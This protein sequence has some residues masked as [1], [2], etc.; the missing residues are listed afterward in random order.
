MFPSLVVAAAVSLSPQ[1]ELPQFN[2]FASSNVSRPMKLEALSPDLRDLVTRGTVSSVERR[3]GVPTFFWASR[4]KGGALRDIGLTPEQA[5]RRYLFA[6]AALYRLQPA[7]LADARLARLHDIGQGAIV[8]TFQKDA[9][10]IKVFNDE[11][12]IVMNQK[13]ELIAITGYV[14]PV[15]RVLGT[16]DLTPETAVGVAYAELKGA[17]LEAGMLS[18]LRPDGAGFNRYALSGETTPVRARKVYFALP[19]GLTPGYQLELSVA[20][21]YYSY[22]VSAKDGALL[23]RNNL[24][25]NDFS[26]RVWADNTPLRMPLDGPQGDDPTPHPTGMP[27]DYNPPFVTNTL[28]T[29]AN[30]PI[31]TND[32]WLA[33]TA[34]TTDGNNT[35]A[36]ADL[37]APDGFS[38]GD[39]MPDVTMP[40]VFDRTYDVTVSPGVT[41]DQTKAA[42]TQ[43]FYDVN[44]FHDWYYDVGFDEKAGNGQ[45]SNYGRGG[46][47]GDPVLAEGQDYSGRNNSDMSTPSDGASPRMQMYIFD[48]GVPAW[49]NIVG[50]NQMVTA[51]VADF[52]AQLFDLTAELA[53]ANDNSS[54]PTLGCGTTW[55]N[56]VAGKIAVVDRGTCTFVQKAENAQANGAIGVLILNNQA[57]GAIPMPG[58]S[59]IATIPVLSMGRTDGTS[60]KAKMMMGATSVE[61]KRVPVTDRDGTIDNAIVAHEWGHYIQNRLVGDGNGLTNNQGTG[62]GEG[63]SD[64]HAMLLVVK[65]EDAQRPANQNYNG[66]YALAGYTMYGQDPNAYYWGIRR[67]PYSTDMTKNPFTFKHIQEGT[68]LP[69]T[70]PLSFGQNG[71]GNSEVHNTGEVWSEMLWECYASLLRDT[72]RLTFEQA[73]DR[74][75]A[76]L[77]AAYK[78]TPILPTFVEARDAILASAI[79]ADPTDFALFW[80][81]FAKRGI[82]M[83]AVAPDRD[84]QDNIPVVESFLVGNDLQII[85]VTLDDSVTSCDNDGNLDLGETGK[86][87]VT[88]KN[89]G[90]G[91]L[92]QTTGTVTSSMTGLRV[93]GGNSITFPPIPPFGIA[94]ATVQVTLDSAPGNT[95]APFSIQ[96]SDPSL[97]KPGPVT[98]TPQFRVN[99]DAKPNGSFT[100]D[101]EAPVTAWTFSDDPNGV[102]G[103]DFRIYADSATSHWFF[104]PDPDAPA[105]TYL[106]SPLMVAG[107]GPVSFTFVH[108]YQ[109]ET[110]AQNNYD[111]AV[112]EI[113]SGTSGWQDLGSKLSQPYDAKISVG[114]NNPIEGRMAFTGQSMNYPA[115][116]P[117]TVD[118]GTQYAGKSFKIRFRVGS[119]DAVGLKGWE[120]DNFAFVGIAS[121]PFPSVVTDP[122]S[123]TN[124]PPVVQQPPVRTVDEGS[125]VVLSAIA[126]DPD[127]DMVT[128]AFTQIAGPLVPMTGGDAFDAPMVDKDTELDFQVIASDGRATSAPVTQVVIVRNVNKPPVAA[129]TP[130]TQTVDEGTMVT[131]TGSA[132]DPEGDAIAAYK[133]TQ[134]S[135]PAVS[136]TGASTATLT[137]TAPQV[138]ADTVMTFQLVAN[139]G[140]SDGPGAL[141]TVTV[142]NVGG[143]MNMMP[144]PMPTPTPKGC[145]CGASDTTATAWMA[146][147]FAMMFVW[148]R[149]RRR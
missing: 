67:A 65:G 133:W 43:M 72:Q 17:P 117:V 115:W 147:L 52:G 83:G 11:I 126:S 119:D 105:D 12:K 47:E 39:L 37:N 33:A 114:G 136:L 118:L 24:T 54:A 57:G 124:R 41:A 53:L 63:W 74:M 102:T 75:R 134:K 14:T 80:G 34:T 62:M 138:D 50:G 84:A 40:G 130:A 121:G 144:Q 77:V 97:L 16:F 31:S 88:V 112:V 4:E 131:I 145:G 139:D 71:V 20:G 141:A 29:L 99:F 143:D 82:G 30:G 3:Y 55:A 123:C 149:R 128:V 70:A 111:G 6:Y 87:T 15:R 103:S 106:I 109:F 110:D 101:V 73:R 9:G 49:L 95:Q 69:T 96:I 98:A 92:S 21:H 8:A 66:V 120:L 125:H 68:P 90:V 76:Y 64:F 113:Y 104:G 46:I 45:V 19:N 140:N 36:Y 2:A 142:H 1:A 22:V 100:D 44:F 108:R 93:V 5:A 94:T 107:Q 122:N 78:I 91:V 13:L 135:G 81:A 129:V 38:N 18:A 137:F 116:L 56:N 59:M 146:A 89:D 42:V 148:S 85:K 26:Y 10:G 60:L 27:D 86:L 132:M 25:R 28:T 7:T 48:G 79:A 51:G 35:R 23:M 61:M 32:P 58:S 127:G